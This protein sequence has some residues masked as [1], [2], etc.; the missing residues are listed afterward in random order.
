MFLSMGAVAFAARSQTELYATGAGERTLFGEGTHQLTPQEDR[1]ARLA[2][3]GASNREIAGRLFISPR[4]V[5]YHLHKVFRKLGVRSRI[6]LWR[7]LE[8]VDEAT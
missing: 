4:T 1:I 5:E 7:N 6:D 3:G 8:E 2:A